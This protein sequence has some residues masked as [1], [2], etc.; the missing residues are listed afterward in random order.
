MLAAERGDAIR[1]RALIAAHARLDSRDNDGRTALFLAA[2]SNQTPEITLSG[3]K[4]CLNCLK[5]LIAAGADVN[6]SDDDG[7]TP[8]MA[9]ASGHLDSVEALIAAGADVSARRGGSFTV[10]TALQFAEHYPPIIAALQRAQRNPPKVAPQ[11]ASASKVGGRLL[12]IDL[13][14]KT[15]QVVPWNS[16]EYQFKSDSIRALHWTDATLLK[17]G[18]SLLT[19][20]AFLGGTPLNRQ[21][22]FGGIT[23]QLRTAGDLQGGLFDFY[24]DQEDGK[25]VV[26]KMSGVIAFP[27]M[28]FAGQVP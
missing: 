8:L 28:S 5:Q 26:R 4:G 10:Q 3:L 7:T 20:A 19:M 12:S 23:E 1:V 15:L 16:T 13:A 17:S 22:M 24:I 25:F 14:N 27:G 11:R 9:A 18:S 6:A 2:G 21:D